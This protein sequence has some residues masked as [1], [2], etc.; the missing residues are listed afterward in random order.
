MSQ[1]AI[2]LGAV[3]V[4]PLYLGVVIAGLGDGALGVV[5]GDPGGNPTECFEGPAVAAQP[6]LH[7]LVAHQF[8]VLVAASGQHHH[9]HPGLEALAAVDI[10]DHRPGAEVD[11]GHIAGLEVEHRGDHG[12]GCFHA[13]QIL[14]D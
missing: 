10:G 14:A 4:G 2:P 5:D 11:L 13:L 3:A 6:G 12:V 8:G 1:E 7:L 9:E